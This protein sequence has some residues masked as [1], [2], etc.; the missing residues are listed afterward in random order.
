MTNNASLATDVVV[1]AAHRITW[2]WHVLLIERRDD[3]HAGL[4]AL[5][6]GYVDRDEPTEFA[7]RRELAEET[8]LAALGPLEPVGSTPSRTAT[9]AAGW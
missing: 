4:Y 3:P 1:L 8:G 9:R 2:E 7:A 5:P 6:G